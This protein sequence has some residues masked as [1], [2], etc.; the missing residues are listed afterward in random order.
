VVLKKAVGLVQEEWKKGGLNPSSSK[1]DLADGEEA[2][3]EGEEEEV[4]EELDPKA[5]K[6]RVEDLV[7]KITIVSFEN[8]R[9]GTLERHKII[10]AALLCF[11][12]LAQQEAIPQAKVDQLISGKPFL[13]SVTQSENMKFLPE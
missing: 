2:D 10:I 9:R 13:G 3:K 7:E 6:Q 5:L 11:R 8:I 12:I 4:I 1:E